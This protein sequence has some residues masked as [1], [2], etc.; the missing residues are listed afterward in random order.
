[1]DHRI[2]LVIALMKD[3]HGWKLPLGEL[4]ETANLSL[5]RFH[6]L[7]K[8][9]TGATPAQYRRL[10]RMEKAADLLGTTLLSVRQIKTRLGINDRSHFEREFKK[11]YGLTPVQYRAT[12]FTSGA[13]KLH[14]Q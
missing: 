11:V 2:K 9:E 12:V 14:G 1:V 3:D 7:F 5:S 10:L 6:S 8:A 4:A 13:L